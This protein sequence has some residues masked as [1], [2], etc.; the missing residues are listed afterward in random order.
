MDSSFIKHHLPGEVYTGPEIPVYHD[1]KYPLDHF[2]AWGCR[3]IED[4][5]NVLVC[6]HTGSGKTVLALYAI[7]RCL[8]RGERVVY[9]SPIKT[10]SNQKYKEFGEAFGGASVGILTGDIKI[11]PDAPCLILTAEILR[12][13]L[14]LKKTMEEEKE[15]ETEK[16]AAVTAAFSM[17][18]VTCVVL[19]EV[20][21]INNEDRGRIWEEILARLDPS[22]R[23]VMLSATL[24]DPLDFVS[25]IGHLKKVPCH[26]VSTAK[27]PVPL[28]HALYWN[29]RLHVFLQEDTWKH[30]VLN[31][32]SRDIEKHYKKHHWTS[33][34]F[35]ECIDYLQREELTPTTVFLLNRE[36]VEK[37]AKA[38]R[39][40]QTDPDA[41][42]RIEYL[43]NRH[44]H[45]YASIYETT[46]QWNLV[47]DLLWKGIGIHHSGMIPLLKEMVEIVY[48]E[49]LLPVLLATETFALGVNAPTKSTVF[50]N[51]SKFDGKTRRILHSDEYLQMAGRAGRRGL[52]KTGTVVLLPHP[53]MPSEDAIRQ[54]ATAPPKSIQ[55]RL[56]MDFTTAMGGIDG[57]EGTLFY[58]QQDRA[59]PSPLMK[60]MEDIAPSI[61]YTLEDE[62]L[63]KELCACEEALRPDGYIRPNKKVEKTLKKRIS[64]IRRHL[65]EETISFLTKHHAAIRRRE[66]VEAQTVFHRDRWGMQIESIHGFLRDEGFMETR[67]GILLRTIH[68]GNAILVS[69][70]L[71]S[72]LLDSLPASSMVA[73]LSL[74]VADKEKQDLIWKDL[75]IST[76]EET[77]AKVVF[78]WADEYQNK[79]L[80]LVQKLPFAFSTDWELSRTMMWC[81]K[82]WYE[83]RP[84]HEMVM[85]FHDF[86]G[87]FIKNIL[88]LT[89]FIQSV[90]QACS[91][92]QHVPI[93]TQLQDIQVKMMR[94]IVLNDSLYIQ[95]L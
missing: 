67:R 38:I 77:I 29:D 55:S 50:T 84:W 21:F 86:E 17:E 10:L 89:N 51:L 5:E 68:D 56:S 19:D 25:W 78:G 37:Q 13:A 1:F 80:E 35:L 72:D 3:A 48:T 33:A 31:E 28:R 59:A 36:M 66:E 9:V 92:I 70:L 14:L 2:Q 15:K 82:E 87:N 27:R 42:A 4:G 75:K 30:G 73:I 60:E 45:R 46:A 95:K 83:G 71:D 65:S 34:L 8:A 41:L 6:A 40:M 20:H 44:L 16:A 74:F 12:N 64:E 90:Y 18:G 39:P 24:S 93:L 53:Y 91:I 58:R 94:D 81:A 52:D 61:Q 62:I 32:T 7:A 54:M 69:R 11:A 76:E 47:R 79:E 49:G 23:L 26:L 85:H 57:L 22:I 88:R 43:W 63:F